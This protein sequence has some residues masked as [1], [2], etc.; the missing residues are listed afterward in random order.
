MSNTDDSERLTDLLSTER[1]SSYIRASDGDTDAAFMLYEWN[2]RASAAVTM[3]T[4]M[5]EVIVRNALDRAMNR[6][7][8]E[9]DYA[10]WLESVP[11]DD[12]GIADIAKARARATRDGRDPLAHG[13]VIAELTFGFWRY[14]VASRYLT[15]LWTPAL[16]HAFPHGVRDITR[17]R[18]E[19]D[20]ELQR[21]M[22]V[23]NRAAHHEPIFRRDLRADQ[24]SALRITSWVDPVAAQWVERISELNT[25]YDARPT[26]LDPRTSSA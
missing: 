11:L 12:R 2:M 7:A 26:T 6:W 23:R 24:T 16:H 21:L 25:I 4:G 17:R 22:L 9:R 18:S 10:S 5:V 13:K 14:L 8:E 3:T 1:L 19:V 20:A 15:S